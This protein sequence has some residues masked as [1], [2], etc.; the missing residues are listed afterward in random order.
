[1][2]APERSLW[3]RLTG[4]FVV[5]R[6]NGYKEDRPEM[7]LRVVGSEPIHH[8]LIADDS[9]SER[10]YLQETLA[11]PGRRFVHASSGEAALQLAVQIRPEVILCDVVMPGMDGLGFIR[12]VRVM[13]A[14][15]HTPL[16]LLTSWDQLDGRAEGLE[17]GADDYLIRPVNPRELCA[18]VNALLRVSHLA[19]ALSDTVR[20]LATA[21]QEIATLKAEIAILK[22]RLKPKPVG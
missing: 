19:K 5:C 7:A 3:S 20:E 9:A 16:V 18:R 2:P 21:R 4:H 1:M 22:S 14:I 10:A 17:L 8:V 13:P 12:A 15:A 6:H 11:A